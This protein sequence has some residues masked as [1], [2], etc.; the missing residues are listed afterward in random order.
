MIVIVDY[1]IS[2]I[3][4]VKNALEFLKI[5]S[6]IS[7]S[8]DEIKGAKKIII[9]GNGNFGEGI[10][11]LKTTG[12]YNVLN[13]LVLNKKIPILG[14]C[15][16]YQLMFEESEEDKNFRGFGWIEG[17]VKKFRDKKN[18]LFHM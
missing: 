1:G 12:I 15:L 6:I 8:K 16:G 2:N 17:K 4:A 13:D 14:I 9:P 7:S 10:R 11:L 3:G 5:R 18:F